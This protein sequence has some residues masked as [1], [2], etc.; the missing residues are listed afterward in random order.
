MAEERR[1]IWGLSLRDAVILAIIAAATA[2]AKLALRIP[3]GIPG[4]F[5]IIWMFFLVFGCALVP[6]RGAGTILGILTG[7][8]A[9]VMGFGH[10]G[11]IVFFKWLIVGL[12]LEIFGLVKKDFAHNPVTATSAG[13]VAAIVKTVFGLALFSLLGI[14]GKAIETVSAIAV[15]LNF[16]F[17]AAGGLIAWAVW[18]RIDGSFRA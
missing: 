6:K 16:I 7:L 12:S 3:L 13:G 4:H 18:K 17:G 8:L 9:M 5:S 15:L 1:Y 14:S 2:A 11:F 10:E